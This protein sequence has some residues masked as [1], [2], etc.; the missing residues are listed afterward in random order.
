MRSSASK[1][2]AFVRATAPAFSFS[3]LALISSA[4]APFATLLDYG[5]Q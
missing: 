1:G 3:F 5:S 2:T 4:G